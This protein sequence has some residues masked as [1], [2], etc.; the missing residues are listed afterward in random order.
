V[1]KLTAALVATGLVGVAE[2]GV[3]QHAQGLR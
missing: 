2:P 1:I 3:L